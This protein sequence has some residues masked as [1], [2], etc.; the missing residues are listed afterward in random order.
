MNRAEP[1]YSVPLFNPPFDFGHNLANSVVRHAKGEFSL[2]S[3]VAAYD[4]IKYGSISF[5]IPRG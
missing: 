4:Q 5:L 1:L 2:L 3:S